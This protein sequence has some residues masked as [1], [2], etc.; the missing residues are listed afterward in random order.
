[1]KIKE[2]LYF[3]LLTLIGSSLSY[4]IHSVQEITVNDPYIN[5][6]DKIGFFFNMDFAMPSDYYLRIKTDKKLNVD[7]DVLISSM[8]SICEVD[9][10]ANA[11][12]AS[13]TKLTSNQE[14][15][16]FIK[17][18]SSLSKNRNY[19]LWFK[20]TSPISGK[21]TTGTPVTIAVVPNV[22][23]PTVNPANIA[24]NPSFGTF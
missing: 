13:T 14:V 19:Q 15:Y 3:L 10:P 8:T 4:Q 16:I 18:E 23:L 5:R 2:F 9:I 22:V 7:M 21:I 12:K 1:M 20:L 11:V 6:A 17:F 24:Y